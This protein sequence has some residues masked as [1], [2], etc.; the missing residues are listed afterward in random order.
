MR[1]SALSLL[2]CL[3]LLAACGEVLG[4][5]FGGLGGGGGGGGGGNAAPPRDVD[6]ARIEAV[7]MIIAV[8]KTDGTVTN[9]AQLAVFANTEN[10][11][12]YIGGIV[13]QRIVFNEEEYPLL[14]TETAGVFATNTTR[15]PGFEW[16]AGATYEFRFTVIDQEGKRRD[17]AQPIAAPE[18]LHAV[19][20]PNDIV[21][22]A[23]EPVSLELFD[24]PTAGAIA[25]TT[26]ANPAAA[27]WT[28]FVFEGPAKVTEALNSLLAV[29]GPAYE[30]PGSAFPQPGL[31]RI[32]VHG[33][34]VARATD[35]PEETRLGASSWFTAGRAVVFE[36]EV[37]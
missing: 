4:V 37:N 26:A 21:F 29:D 16:V 3:F 22:Y 36:I 20:V 10:G 6:T 35:A 27:T 7:G 12:N 34:D 32:E 18:V 15:T 1:R 30:I 17:F 8:P 2:P 13:E 24:M 19:E 28:S 9:S 23:Q 14:S 5:P 31:Y 11:A 25:V 33:Y